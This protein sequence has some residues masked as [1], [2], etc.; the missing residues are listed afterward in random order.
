MKKAYSIFLVL[1]L[2]VG[3]LAACGPD[4]EEG[5]GGNEGSN[6]DGAKP[7]KL[8]VWEDTDRS[9][10]LEPAAKAF[11]E[12]HG[13]KVEF[14][15]YGMAEDMRNQIRLDG[16]AGK[17]PDVLT[18]PMTKLVCLL[19]KEQSKKF[20]SNKAFLTLSRNHPSK[21]KPMM[22]NYM[23]WRRHLNTRIYLQ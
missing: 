12:E 22:V 14:K 5:A 6:A 1:M 16:P 4:R 11:E 19:K 21:H 18:L 3:I 8:V 10:A 20:Q 7:E 9:V 13:I 17:G 15:E 2:A 23:A